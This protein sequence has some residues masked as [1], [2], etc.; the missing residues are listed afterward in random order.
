M[1]ETGEIVGL[2]MLEKARMDVMETYCGI[3]FPGLVHTQESL[4]RAVT[5]QFQDTDII[6]ATYPKSGTTWTQ[7][8]VTLITRRGDPHLS[9]TVPNWV[10]AP[11][12]EHIY[13]EDALKASS[14]TPRILTTHFPYQLLSSALQGSKVKVIYVSRNPKDVAV[15]Y[16]HF[17]KMAEFFP[18]FT[19]FQEFLHQFLEGK[20]PYGSWF[21][22]V[23]DWTSQTTTMNN[24]FTITYEELWQDPHDAIKRM[25]SF[26][27]CPLEENEVNNCVKHS[28]FRAMKENKMANSTLLP[29]HVMNHSKGSFM[30]KGKIGDWKNMFTEEQ[31]QYFKSIYESKMNDW[32]SEIVWEV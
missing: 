30:R 27:H 4:Q 10:R 21:D 17:C 26:L 9:E 15:S 20:V 14:S 3:I 32:S 25:S 11:W 28:S 2:S 18:S 16:Y 5:F 1:S 8:I 29:E 6:I 12:L 7:E 19:T 13:L 22:H 24:L 31:N 23:K